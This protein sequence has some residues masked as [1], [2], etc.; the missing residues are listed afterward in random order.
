MPDCI[1][2]LL[3]AS[4]INR[5]KQGF[6]LPLK[7]WFSDGLGINEFKDIMNFVEK[8]NYFD[9]TEVKKLLTERKD[10]T[11]IWFLLN[12]AL[13]WKVFIKKESHF[14]LVNSK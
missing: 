3:P 12:L 8:T 11:R 14:S 2:S 1:K 5:K 9:P 4:I 13:W 6:G 7:E 10:D